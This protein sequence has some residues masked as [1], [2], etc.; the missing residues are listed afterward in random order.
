MLRQV[1]YDTLS[2]RDRKARHLAV[3]AHLRAAFPGEGEE[4]ADVI[5]RHYLDALD[6]VPGDPDT[7]DIRER[8]IGALIRAAERAGRTGAPGL[9]AA[10]Y[11]TAAELSSDTPGNQ[12]AADGQP[13]AGLLWER[14]ADAADANASWAVAVGHAG[15][16]R[17]YYL[18]HGQARM[19]ARAQAIAG[20]ALRRWGH[21]AEAREQLTAAVE[22]LRADPDADT[23]RAL[24]QL[25]TLEVFAGSPDADQLT[26]EV[27]A[28]GQALGVG[29]GQLVDLFTSR[30]IYLSSAERRP[31]AVA[32]YGEAA[33]LAT[34]AGDNMR[35]GRVLGDMADVLVVTDPAAAME[36]ARTAAEH[37]RRAGTRHY[38]AVAI[39]NLVIALLHLGDWDTAGEELAQAVD[40]DGLADIDYLACFQG[41]VVAL[42]GDADTAQTMSAGLADLR[43][44]EDLQDKA[45]VSMVE[46]FTAAARGQPQD[47][48]RHARSVLAHAGALGISHGY[49]RW[50]WPLAARTAHDLHDTAGTGELLTLLDDCQPGHLAPMLH[51][52][53]DLARARLADHAGEQAAAASYAAAISS[54]REMS[55][56]YHLAHGLLDHAEH[57]IRLHDTEAAEA[58]VSEARDIGSR[59]RCQPL[60][61]RAAALTPAEPR[62]RA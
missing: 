6:A 14:A 2:R 1:A 50:A 57:L 5:A 32:Y 20:Q 59:L 3:A 30:G 58:A 41:W 46:A 49:L 8:A 29:T 38:L 34:Q 53:R 21:Y 39:M 44:S 61:D 55:T 43:A 17:G 4:V 18:D 16:A 27:L 26:L 42:R 23:V 24:G 47:T 11:A 36:A 62:T 45:M 19:A 25:A 12:P 9:A 37:L 40:S 51:A 54:L 10:S 33:R 7:T 60:L 13:D 28:L 22:V 31:E 15:R 56:P 48:L 52:E 35:L